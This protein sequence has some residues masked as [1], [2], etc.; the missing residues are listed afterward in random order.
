MHYRYKVR[1]PAFFY[2]KLTRKVP[3]LMLRETDGRYFSSFVSPT[4]LRLNDANV[5]TARKP[6]GLNRD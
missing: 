6:T 1:R 5:S 2:D 4:N 3:L